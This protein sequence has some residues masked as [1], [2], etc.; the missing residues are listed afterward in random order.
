MSN[1]T[2]DETL[3]DDLM[4]RSLLAEPGTEERKRDTARAIEHLVRSG[5]IRSWALKVAPPQ[6]TLALVDRDEIEQI[7][8]E[9]LLTRFVRM[10]VTEA[11]RVKRWAGWCFWKAKQAVRDR[12]QSA[13]YTVASGMAT[14]LRRYARVKSATGAAQEHLG[15]TPSIAEVIAV[16]NAGR[17]ARARRDGTLVTKEDF[18]NHQFAR[19][20]DEQRDLEG[21]SVDHS[22][23]M[24]PHTEDPTEDVHARQMAR[25]LA[26]GLLSAVREHVGLRPDVEAVGQL[27]LASV[28]DGEPV[29]TAAAIAR[30]LGWSRSRA[31]SELLIWS[32]AVAE[33][34]DSGVLERLRD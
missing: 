34:R 15:R 22:S 33:L 2:L 10:K 32:N 4:V 21:D 25:G 1:T 18:G 24:L 26:L 23:R 17:E 11:A 27:W 7:I 3:L 29:P 12:L 16:A 19:S 28:I 8:V 14:V 6:H 13:S 5:A 30:E 9:D 20:I 31:T